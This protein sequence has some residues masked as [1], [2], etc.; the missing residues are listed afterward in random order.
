MFIAPG[1]DFF[2]DNLEDHPPRQSILFSI[3]T[4]MLLSFSYYDLNYRIEAHEREDVYYTY[5]VRE[6]SI[7]VSQWLDN[8]VEITVFECNDVKRER[9]IAAYSHSISNGDV[10][11]LPSGVVNINDMEIERISVKEM[12]WESL[13]HLW[14]WDNSSNLTLD[15]KKNMTVSVVNLGMADMSGKSSTLS[16]VFDSYY[17]NMPDFTYKIYS[18]EELALYWTF[19]Y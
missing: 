8:S 14:K 4:I 15:A 16:L 7:S 10:E 12:Y 9:R 11:Q 19:E 1:M 6:S 3:F 5:Y 13:D 18:N 2:V 17:E